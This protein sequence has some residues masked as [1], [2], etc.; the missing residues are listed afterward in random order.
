MSLPSF[1]IG[2][3]GS[4]AFSYGIGKQL[5]VRSKIGNNTF[6]E[7]YSDEDSMRTTYSK[8]M[9]S[10][11]KRTEDYYREAISTTMRRQYTDTIN[12]ASSSISYL[13]PSSKSTSS[14]SSSAEST[15]ESDKA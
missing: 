3:G 9:S 10:I 1:V 4:L 2:L 7:Y 13:F 14:P 15:G 11:G 12:K 6:A 5:S 8:I